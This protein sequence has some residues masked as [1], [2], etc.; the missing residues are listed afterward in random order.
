MWKFFS[1]FFAIAACA[2][3]SASA[4]TA[5]GS[6]DP[7]PP[8]AGVIET[9]TIYPGSI[10]LKAKLDTGARTTSLGVLSYK[11]DSWQGK[12]IV[13]FTI[14]LPDGSRQ[15]LSRPLHRISYVKERGRESTGRP[16]VLMTVCVGNL[17]RQTQVNLQDR[18]NF[19][20]ALLI[21]RRYLAGAYS[22]DSARRNI[23]RTECPAAKDI[24]Q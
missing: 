14:Q 15:T 19:N 20:Y 7:G 21:G 10:K 5:T 18:T 11:I 17:V 13:E 24:A 22:V 6:P 23:L 2:A 9:A 16:V 1:A 4:Q 8:H 3:A 12:D